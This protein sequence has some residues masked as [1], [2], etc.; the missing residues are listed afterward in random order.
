MTDCYVQSDAISLFAH[1]PATSNLAPR[2]NREGRCRRGGGAPRLRALVSA[3]TPSY[4]QGVP[5]PKV[6]RLLSLCCRRWLLL[7]IYTCTSREVSTM[8]ASFTHQGTFF[9]PRRPFRY[10]RRDEM[11][12]KGPVVVRIIHDTKDYRCRT[13]KYRMYLGLWT[14]QSPATS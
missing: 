13:Y 11:E 7:P 6:A 14:P 4:L 12:E 9:V 1:L 10:D 2:S 5:N 3:Y 8:A